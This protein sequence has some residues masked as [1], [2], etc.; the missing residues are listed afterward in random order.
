[1]LP[2]LKKLIIGAN[3]KSAIVGVLLSKNLVF[4]KKIP[5]YLSYSIKERERETR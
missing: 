2:T 4:A 5:A 1:M 3:L